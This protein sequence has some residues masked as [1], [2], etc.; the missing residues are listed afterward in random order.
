[1][2]QPTALALSRPSTIQSSGR[3]CSRAR[4]RRSSKSGFRLKNEPWLWSAFVWFL[5]TTAAPAAE[6]EPVEAL[7][8]RIAPGFH[9]SLYADSDLANDIFAMTL[10][11]QGRVVVTGPGYIKTLH[12]TDDDDKADKASL[13]ATTATGGMGLCFSG[14]I[15]Y[16]TGD[17]ALSRYRDS[18]GDG[19][20][21]GPPE[22]LLP[23]AFSEHGG[24][25]MRQGPDG[26]WYFIGGNDSRFNRKQI[27]LPHSPVRDPEAGALWR[28]S[29]DGKKT[30]VVAQGFRNPYDFDF[31][32]MGDI[33]TYDSDVESDFLLPWYTPTRLYHIGYAGHHGWRLNGWTRSWN[34]PDYY[35][36]TVDILAPVGR[37]SP[38]GV[39]SYRHTQFPQHYRDGIFALDWTFGR[40]Y[41]FPLKSDGTSYQT[42]PELFLEP[43]GS[44]GFA[45]TD[46]AVAPDGSLLVSIGGRKTRGA[47][48]KIRYGERP[49][50][51]QPEPVA[52]RIREEEPTDEA[53]LRKVLNAP[54]PL[55]AWSRA[56]WVPLAQK[57]G[58]HPFKLAV[59]NDRL[60]PAQRVRAI[61]IMTEWFGGL[62]TARA[63]VAAKSSS[64]QVRARVAWSVGRVPCDEVGMVLLPLAKDNSILVRRCALEALA[65]QMEQ[66]LS[67]E[68]VKVLPINLAHPDKRLRQAAARL[69]ALLPD[70]AWKQLRAQSEKTGNQ[71]RLT[72]AFAATLRNPGAPVHPD[73]L[74]MV[75]PVLEKTTDF[76]L[77]LQGVRLLILALGDYHL[78]SP[79]VE[80][81]TA[82]E[83]PRAWSGQEATLGRI[84]R[85]LHDSFPTGDDKLDAESARLLAM[86]EDGQPELIEAVANFF[87]EESSPTADFHYLTVLSRLPGERRA[88]LAA[89]VA[90][91]ILNLDRKLE[92]PAPRTRQNWNARLVEVVAKLAGRDPQLPDELLKHPAFATPRHVHLAE[93]FRPDQREAAARLYKSAVQKDRNFGWSRTL[94]DLLAEL[95]AEESH[96]LF[97][98]QWP[99]LNLRGAILSQLGK[100]PAVLDREKF[101]EGLESSQPE[102][103]QACLAALA[104]LPRDAQ[105]DRLLPLLRLLQRLQSD[106]PRQAL[107]RQTVALVNR[108]SSQAFDVREDRSDRSSLKQ[109]YQPV[110]A[111]FQQT[112]PKLA[113]LLDSPG[114]E[115]PEKWNSLMRTVAWEK[116]DASRGEALFRARACQTCHASANALGPDLTGA[117]GRFS[118]ADLFAAIIFPNHDVAPPYRATIFE[119]KDGQTHSGLVA[120]ESADG[121]IVQ[122]GAAATVRLSSAE[123]LSRK[124]SS[125]SLMP[126]GL[127]EGLRAEDLADLYS[128]LKSLPASNRGF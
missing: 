105:P 42:E 110:L 41:F 95:P 46:A 66:V 51:P 126:G 35:L 45:P 12:D 91:A 6:L 62:E 27:T 128:F 112:Y 83:L 1:M 72:S 47:V 123:I 97:R 86:L 109:A 7:G 10:D 8:L 21:D 3:H 101:L 30:E 56:I 68:V 59:V 75:I 73:V 23:A 84:R 5:I 96:P 24:H 122:T 34:R 80:V 106:A 118:R 33:F 111:W 50:P 25:A 43:I 16:F 67:A 124:P 104:Q 108:Q 53:L 52:R 61:E 58:A 92:G 98:E 49:I 102:I 100:S 71:A 55:D 125:V 94:V 127:L 64:P 69:A 114:E 17:G 117:A 65:D 60:P 116:G 40:I 70:E 121:V 81:Y 38:T 29:P 119:T 11:A 76:K 99:E 37:G 63:I 78:Q 9:V 13:F 4:A 22:S 115:A 79:S 57:L 103:V 89:K 87:T 44:H 18:D 85:N 19:K 77:R 31:N 74:S 20:A 2:P 113:A 36:D 88:G 39:A 82:Y 90:G 48:F 14:N 54:Q 32:A 120:F 107:R 26:W 93:A 15:L 28:L